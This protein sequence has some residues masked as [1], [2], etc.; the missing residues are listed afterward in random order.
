MTEQQSYTKI[1][2]EIMDNVRHKL[3]LAESTEDVKKEFVYAVERLFDEVFYGGLPITADDIFLDA[4]AEPW[5]HFSERLE[6]AE[7]LQ[8]ERQTSDL[9]NIIERLALKASKR[10]RHLEKHPEK[11]E[12]KIFPTP[13]QES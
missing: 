12:A 10:Y 8:Q 1:E 6:R 7:R 2:R 5:Y 11:T 13:R 3:D 4:E 9:P